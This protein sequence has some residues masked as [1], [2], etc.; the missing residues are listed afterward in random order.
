MTTTYLDWEPL[1]ASVANEFAR[2][3]GRYG[4]EREDLAQEMRVWIFRHPAK[5]AEW[6]ESEEGAEKPLARTLR[7]EALDLCQRWKADYLGY[8]VNDLHYYSRKEL[9]KVLLPAL[10]D[11]EAWTEPP[12]SEDSGRSGTAP[13]EGGNWVSLLADVSRAFDGLPKRDQD[14]LRMFHQDQ[15]TNVLVADMLGISQQAASKK[16]HQALGRLVRQL[17]GERPRNTHEEPTCECEDFVGTRQVMSNAAARAA[18]DSY[19]EDRA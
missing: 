19:Y 2:K 12:V 3:F 15:M 14:L 11:R 13:G 4:V 6:E 8:S 7:N 9:Q 18:Q 17:G 1:V 16:H 10:F 5:L